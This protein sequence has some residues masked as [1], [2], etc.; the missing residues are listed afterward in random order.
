MPSRWSKK[1]KWPRKLIILIE[2][3]PIKVMHL[4]FNL[5]ESS[6]FTLKEMD[7]CAILD[8]EMLALVLDGNHDKK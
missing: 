2:G 8:Q 4:S 3:E 7:F 6:L 1:G 5:S